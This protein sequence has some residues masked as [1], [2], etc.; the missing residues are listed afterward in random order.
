MELMCVMLQNHYYNPNLHPKCFG[1]N[2]YQS[3]LPVFQIVISYEPVHG[4]K[5]KLIEFI[6][7]LPQFLMEHVSSIHLLALT[8]LQTSR[9]QVTRILEKK[10]SILLRN[11]SKIGLSTT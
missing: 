4:R 8:Q 1:C 3:T 6:Y 9:S 7:S 10:V 5:V 2:V 11:L